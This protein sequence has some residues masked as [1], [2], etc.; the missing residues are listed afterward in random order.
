[1]GKAELRA[2]LSALG[3]RGGEAGKGAAK[4]RGGSDHYKRLAA[5]AAKARAAKRREVSK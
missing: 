1:M 3:K 4:K 5:K 2:Y